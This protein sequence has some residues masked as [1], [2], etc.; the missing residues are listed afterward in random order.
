MYNPHAEMRSRLWRSGKL[1]FIF[2][3]ATSQDFTYL[4]TRHLQPQHHVALYQT[5]QQLPLEPQNTFVQFSWMQL[6]TPKQ[7]AHINVKNHSD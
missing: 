7:Y 2:S 5:V 6:Y 4:H 1:M 3:D